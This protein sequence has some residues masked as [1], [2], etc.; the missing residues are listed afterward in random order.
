[1][2]PRAEPAFTM[3]SLREITIFLISQSIEV[4]QNVPQANLVIS[5]IYHTLNIKKRKILKNK[6][7]NIKKLHTFAR[8][9]LPYVFHPS[10]SFLNYI[11]NF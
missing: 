10:Q 7:E 8:V 11:S 3:L 1:M 2:A 4:P 5:L 6:K 9:I